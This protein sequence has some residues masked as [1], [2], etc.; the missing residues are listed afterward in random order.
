M[1]TLPRAVIMP[2]RAAVVASWLPFFLGLLAPLALRKVKC[3]VAAH[4]PSMWGQ[5]VVL[6][7]DA[8]G[9]RHHSASDTDG[10]SRTQSGRILRLSHREVSFMELVCGGCGTPGGD[11]G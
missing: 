6:S 3:S 7:P 9:A 2:H 4:L 8:V 1:A 11:E 10:L 5:L